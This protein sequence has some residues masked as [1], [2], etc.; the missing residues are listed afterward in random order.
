[1]DILTLFCDF[2]EFCKAFEPLWS[3]HLLEAERKKRNR[4]R[5]LARSEV[6][7]LLVLFH[8]SGYRNLKTFY[9]QFVCQHLRA[10]FP[11]LVSYSRFVEYERDALIPLA[12]YLQTRRGACTGISFVDS[13]KSQCAKTCVSHSIGS[14]LIVPDAGKPRSDGSLASSYTFVSMSAA[15]CCHGLSRQAMSMTVAAY[16]I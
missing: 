16:R 11:R 15:N 7:T 4:P 14:S 1:M 12:A 3:K 13:T 9:L 8:L 6:L 2:D 10:E 5:Q